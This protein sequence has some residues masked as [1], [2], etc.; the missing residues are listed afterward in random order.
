MPRTGRGEVRAPEG[1]EHSTRQAL[2]AM[3]SRSRCPEGF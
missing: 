3:L 1:L 2:N